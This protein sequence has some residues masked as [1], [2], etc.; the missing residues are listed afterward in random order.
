MTGALA[1]LASCN[2]Y[3]DVI[4]D[5][6]AT[7]DNAFTM[8]SE[9]EKYL[10]TCYSYLPAEGDPQWNPAFVAGDEFWQFYPVTNFNSNSLQIARGNQNIVD[11][12]LNYWDG[13]QGGQP[14][15]TAL[16][17]CNIFLENVDNVIDL[18]PY[19]KVRWVAEVKFLKAYYHFWLLRMYGPV[20]IIHENL[21]IS[22]SVEEVKVSRQPVD[23][24]VNYIVGLLDEA[25]ADLPVVVPDQTSELGRVT[26]LAALGIKARVLMLA[27]S[28]LFNGNADFANFANPD[29]TM[30]FSASSDP[31]KWK[32]A[33]E[34]CREAIEACHAAGKEL[35]YFPSTLYDISET[36]KVKMNIRNSIGER[37]NEELV[38]G[39]SNSTGNYIQRLAMARIDPSRLINE[40]A[41]GQ[42]APTMRM[43]ELF[44]SENGVPISEDKTWDY[45]NRYALKIASSEDRFNLKEGYET[46]A[47]HFDREPRFY[48]DL[49]FDGAIWYGQGKYDDTQPWHVE[50]KMDQTSA[51]KG[52]GR[53]SITG[54]FPKKLVNWNFIIQDAQDLSIEEYPWP[55]MRLAD[56]Y[57]LY[58]EAL[59]ESAGPGAEVYQWLNLVRE[60]AGLK[61]VEE[62]WSTYSRQPDKYTSREGLR[63]IIHQER[64]IEMAF[65]G[66]RYWDLRRWKKADDAFNGPVLGWDVEKA[67][68]ESYYRPRVLFKQ[69]FRAPRDYFW[70]I[71]EQ[72]T[73]VNRKLVQSLGW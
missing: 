49:A 47:L 38:W 12:Y 54:Y 53:Y 69:T 57:L 4:P 39:S 22:S 58:A 29:G 15:F 45:A 70:P 42:L 59:N 6:V 25:A 8:R 26:R 9:A 30:L 68:A 41:L 48:A 27:A 44:Y 60:R 65:E 63:E 23:S 2:N 73:V 7:I 43:A 19:M 21:P 66:H 32:R 31:E 64:M 35:Y 34:A 37:W 56:L 50:A 28:P 24:V 55:I 40:Q 14:L 51:R 62:S 18:E 10:F 20:P 33:A 61:T 13:L 46:V 67:D 11:P 16:R 36:T 52:V 71:R 1:I 72:N 3:L 17:D 5:N